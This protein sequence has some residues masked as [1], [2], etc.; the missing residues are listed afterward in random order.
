MLAFLGN[1]PRLAKEKEMETK[2]NAKAHIHIE[3]FNEQLKKFFLAVRIISS[4]LAQIA[5]QMVVHVAYCLLNFQ[6]PLCK[7]V[8]FLLFKLLFFPTCRYICNTILFNDP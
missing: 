8:D 1:R 4:S 3:R 5:A 2:L 6:Q 7:S